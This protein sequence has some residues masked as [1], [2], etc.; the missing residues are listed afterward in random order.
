MA[1]IKQSGCARNRAVLFRELQRL[2]DEDFEKLIKAERKRRRQTAWL[3]GQERDR[4]HYRR[5]LTKNDQLE[6]MRRAER[7]GRS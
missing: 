7:W 6:I 4:W 1:D 5:G 3:F 2:S